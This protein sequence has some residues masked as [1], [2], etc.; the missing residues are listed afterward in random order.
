MLSKYFQLINL[1]RNN[2][3]RYFNKANNSNSSNC[4]IDQIKEKKI[5]FSY[6]LI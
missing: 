3:T 1:A 5:P 4:L 6:Y 2:L